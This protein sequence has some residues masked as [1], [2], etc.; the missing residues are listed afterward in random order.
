MNKKVEIYYHNQL[1]VNS[2]MN[3]CLGAFLLIPAIVVLLNSHYSGLILILAYL[4][5]VTFRKGTIIDLE[6]Q[7]IKF[8]KNWIYI[9]KTGR[10]ESLSKFSHYQIKSVNKTFQLGSR[11]QTARYSQK[12]H[13][14]EL[15]DKEKGEYR[16]VILSEYKKIQ[17]V[18]ES[19]EKIGFQ[20]NL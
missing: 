12:F 3:G 13:S 8:F 7:R 17:Q 11:V 14:L 18:K 6:N 20:D 15:F 4:I 2:F 19:L 1:I 9:L 10:W 16:L 5:I